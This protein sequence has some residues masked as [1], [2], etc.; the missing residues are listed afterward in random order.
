MLLLKKTK[1]GSSNSALRLCGSI[2]TCDM[3]AMG[4]DILRSRKPCVVIVASVMVKG[5]TDSLIAW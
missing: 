1:F 4:D 5:A 3:I 2:L